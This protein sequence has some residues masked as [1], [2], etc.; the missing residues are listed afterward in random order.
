MAAAWG[1]GD[2]QQVAT[3]ARSQGLQDAQRGTA[4]I[5]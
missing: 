3:G 4:D 1:E 5:K 2:G